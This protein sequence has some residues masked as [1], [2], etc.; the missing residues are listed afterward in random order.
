MMDRAPLPI[1]ATESQHN[2]DDLDL[3]ETSDTKTSDTVHVVPS[4][5]LD[6]NEDTKPVLQELRVAGEGLLTAR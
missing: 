6:E 2:K 5:E 3:I 4:G 1:E